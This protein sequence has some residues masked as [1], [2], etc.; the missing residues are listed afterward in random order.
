ME[1]LRKYMEALRT[2]ARQPLSGN[3]AVAAELQIAAF[4]RTE[5]V[6]SLLMDR[7]GVCEFTSSEARTRRSF[8]LLNRDVIDLRRNARWRNSRSRGWRCR[9]FW[10]S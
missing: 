8:G 10:L 9:E 7:S 2:L 5:G 6:E 3:Q 1:P 4:L